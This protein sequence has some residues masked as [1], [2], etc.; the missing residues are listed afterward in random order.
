MSYTNIASALVLLVLG[1]LVVIRMRSWIIAGWTTAFFVGVS[2][3]LVWS[4]GIKV[5]VSGKTLHGFIFSLPRFGSGLEITIDPLGGAF[6]MLVAA[7]S[8]MAAIYSIGYMTHYRR[9]SPGRFYSLLQLFIASM[10]GV[11]SVADWLFFIV[12]WEL[13]TLVSY[14]L[15]TFERSDPQAMRAGFKYFIMTH[16]ATAGLLVT[17]IYLW[18]LTGSFGFED[19]QAGLGGMIIGVRSLLL[20]LYFV[21]FATKAGVFPLGDWVP[22]VYPAAPSAISAVLSGVTSKVGVYGLLRIFWLNLTH[23][24]TSGEVMTWGSII[25]FLGMLSAFVGGV[26]AMK[27]DDAK[28][29]L[30]LS[31]MSQVGYILLAL[32]IGIAFSKTPGMESV[33]LLGILASGFHILN[34]AIYKSL[35]FMNAG[36]VYYATGTRD[37]NRLGGLWGVMPYVAVAGLVGVLSLAG[38]PP[39]NGF[40]SKWVIYQAAVSGGLKFAPFLVVA[41]V[42]FFVSLSTLA[43]SLKYFNT[44]FLGKPTSEQG[45]PVRV[46]VAMAVSQCLL[47]LVCLVVGLVPALVIRTVGVALGAS[48][49]QAFDM[50]WIGALHTLPVGGGIPASWSPLSLLVV[51]LV[52]LVIAQLIR[53]S[54]AVHTRAVPSWYC[55][56]EHSDDEVRYRAHG[57]YLPFNLAFGKVYPHIPVPRLPSLRGVLSALNFD[58]WL[59]N[60]ILRLGGRLTDKVSRSHVGIPQLYMIWQ[61]AGMILVLALLFVLVK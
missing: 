49:T 9:E 13:M 3:I 35:L 19:H 34:D 53:K 7:V 12:F 2:A 5:L 38:L 4:D 27:E 30:A 58:G 8:F 21:A 23:V 28:R 29:L 16:V 41:V 57:F 14:F 51:L 17:A 46:P 40:A 52:A 61:V 36:S 42:A 56:E 37:L 11:V 55:G 22:D 25:A 48:S 24:G 54:S 6:A 10:I 15:V 33:A 32:G 50:G 59:Y 26:T 1:A 43:Y 60:P 45:P 20:A 39:T 31:S 18:R 44:A 47:A